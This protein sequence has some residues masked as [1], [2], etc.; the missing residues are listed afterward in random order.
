MRT[1]KLFLEVAQEAFVFNRV[2][3]LQATSESEKGFIAGDKIN[4]V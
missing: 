1:K 3:T 4:T 2:L